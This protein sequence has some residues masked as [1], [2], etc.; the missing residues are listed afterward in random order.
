RRRVG[1]GDAGDSH[2]PVERSRL[3]RQHLQTHQP[4]LRARARRRRRHDGRRR[5]VSV[6]L[7]LVEPSQ[8]IDHP[9]GYLALSPKKGRFTVP[10]AR[11]MKLRNKIKRARSLGLKVLEVGAQLPADE[12]TFSR[13]SAIS[14]QWLKAKRKKELDFMIGELGEPGD[15]DRRIFAALDGD[16]RML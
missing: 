6:A 9:S 4:A 8:L 2:P 10:G 15:A 11:R 12:T 16:D 1:V 5:P 13:L 7:S 3:V 14:G